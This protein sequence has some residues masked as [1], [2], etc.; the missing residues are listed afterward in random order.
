MYL[1][2]VLRRVLNI[3][4]YNVIVFNPLNTTEHLLAKIIF[5]T[6]L[7]VLNEGIFVSTTINN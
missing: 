4:K 6:L 2:H 3:Y 5:S 1:L 7:T